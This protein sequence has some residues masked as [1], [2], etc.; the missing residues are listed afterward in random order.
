MRICV[1]PGSFDPFTEGHLDILNN[2]R[3]LFDIV[4]VSVLQNRNKKTTFSVKERVQ[5]IQNIID[6]NGY[7]NVYAESFDGLLIHYAKKKNAGY[8]VRGLRALTDFEY[9]FQLDAANKFLDNSIQTIYF[10]AKPEHLFLSSSFVKELCSYNADI[11]Q[12]VP[13]CNL[14]TILERTKNNE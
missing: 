5:M 6:T 1:Y 14:N 8:I 7:K 3:E 9:E 2:A 10:M 11:N 13:E 12:I 4:Y